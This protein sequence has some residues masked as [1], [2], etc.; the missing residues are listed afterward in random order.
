[1]AWPRTSR[2]ARG[3]G[4]AHDKMRAHLLATVILCEE[5]TRRGRVTPGHIAD[6][7]KP[8]AQGGTGDRSNYQL[9]CQDC[10]DAKT[11]AEK[12]QTAR[13]ATDA[14]GFPTDPTHPWNRARHA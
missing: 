10:S 11:L 2:H 6:H 3:Y 12:G 4:T 5:C 13:G 8:L 1:M 7:I 14:S 9:L